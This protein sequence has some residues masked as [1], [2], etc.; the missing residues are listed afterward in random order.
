MLNFSRRIVYFLLL[1]Q[2]FYKEQKILMAQ[3]VIVYITFTLVGLGY[4]TSSQIEKIVH[5]LS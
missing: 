1:R 2:L 5:V 4:K 3:G